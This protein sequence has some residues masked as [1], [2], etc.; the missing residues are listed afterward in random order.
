MNLAV[1]IIATV[2][3]V[4]FLLWFIPRF[5]DVSVKKRPFTLFWV[6]G[7]LVFQL[8]ADRIL[9]GFDLLYMLGSFL[10]SLGFA[11]T[12]KKKFAIWPIF[13][14]TLFVIEPI[15][16]NSLIYTDFSLFINEMDS[17]MQGAVS[18]VRVIYIIICKLLQFAFYRLMLL[19]FR[20]G[21][22]LNAKSALLSFAFTAATALGLG[23]LMKIAAQSVSRETNVLVLILAIILV[24]MNIILYIMIKQVQ[25]LLHHKYELAILNKQKDF[26]R[27]RMDEVNT[28]WGNIRKL[29]HDLKNH[30]SAISGL[31]EDGKY[32]SGIQYLSELN[33]TVNS[34][35]ELIKSGNTVVDYIINSKLS[36]LDGV[37][38]IVSGY[39]GSFSDIED[40]DMVSILGN[41]LDNAI[42]AQ[43]K[44]IGEKRIELL[45]LRKNTNRVIICKNSV[46]ESVLKNN[47]LLSSTKDSPELHG[48]GHQIVES[49]VKKYNGIIDYFEENNVFGV[50]IILPEK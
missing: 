12:L 47:K 5:N 41:I 43:E 6:L 45:F 18:Y 19:I 20:K 1:E 49:T 8:T 14:A 25:Q 40:I 11:L 26:E 29:K 32:D 28:I 42:E 2:V 36:N 31:L 44:T 16:F 34:M 38:V 37:Q 22:D 50:Q 27:S 46:S 23:A 48:F 4:L 17:V 35:G 10:I 30:F 24:S 13:S 9:Q 3:D 7:L 15:L 33:N 39:V 21:K